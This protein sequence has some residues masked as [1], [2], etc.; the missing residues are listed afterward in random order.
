[1][2]NFDLVS[3]DVSLQKQKKI[4]RIPQD[5]EKYKNL[6]HLVVKYTS[7]HNFK[8]LID[9]VCRSRLPVASHYLPGYE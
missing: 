6:K 7:L 5:K 4:F 2:I 8:Q 1:L 3:E 9:E